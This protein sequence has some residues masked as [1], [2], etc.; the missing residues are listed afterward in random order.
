M[1][2]KVLAYA[3]RAVAFRNK[4]GWY[5]GGM[6][7]ADWPSV[8]KDCETYVRLSEKEYAPGDWSQQSIDNY[9]MECIENR[10]KKFAAVARNWGRNK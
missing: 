3:K 8:L 1:D 4:G 5:P 2:A 10:L 9:K 6:A 7:K